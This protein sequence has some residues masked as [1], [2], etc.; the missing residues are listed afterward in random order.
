MPGFTSYDAILAA[1]SSGAGQ[2]LTF[3]KTLPAAHVA[4]AF[5]TSWACTG[6]PTN[7]AWAGAGGNAAATW[8]TCSS[9]TTG[10]IPIA[11]PT[12]ASATN[13][14]MLS[15]GVMQST[16]TAMAGALILIDRIADT[17]P[18]ITTAGTSCT[19]TMPGGGWA[20]YNDGAGVQIF[21]ESLTTVPSV[22]SVATLTY[23]NQ[24]GVGS[25]TS[26]TATSVAGA[27]RAV[28]TSGPYIAL[29]TTD[30]GA[31]SVESVAIASVT[32][33]A[34]S[35]ALVACKQLLTIPCTTVGYY[36]ERDLVIQTPKLP[37]L[38]VAADATACL[39][40]IFVPN[41]ATTSGAVFL[42]SVST[43]TG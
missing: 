4:G 5:H 36:T 38:Q 2:E 23:T 13:P 27:H 31:R 26:G 34:T 18:L 39:Q 21:M 37:K 32:P 15:T 43:V 35:I 7:G 42:G 41:A 28:G 40:W 11:S 29:Q 12:T 25:H 17:G 9:A 10:A 16:G 22:G 19:L 8:V 6:Y 30:T 33:A 3:S 20:R 24:L 1:L 14:Y